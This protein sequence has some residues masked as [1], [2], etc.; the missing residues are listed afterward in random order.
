MHHHR[1][2]PASAPITYRG[3][4]LIIDPDAAARHLLS[5]FGLD[6]STGAAFTRVWHS[7]AC[8]LASRPDRIPV[9]ADLAGSFPPKDWQAVRRDFPIN[10][11]ADLNAAD[12]K[13]DLTTICFDDAAE[14]FLDADRAVQVLRLYEPAAFTEVVWPNCPVTSLGLTKPVPGMARVLSTWVLRPGSYLLCWRFPHRRP[15]LVT[16]ARTEQEPS[17]EALASLPG[18]QARRLTAVC[19]RCGRGW[20]AG[21][22]TLRF[23]LSVCC[24]FGG[25]WN[26]PEATGRT[27]T[28]VDCPSHECEGGRARLSN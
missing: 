2:Q 28:E 4:R 5:A 7:R 20:V 16:A 15:V 9:T 24:P 13:A 19:D 8:L 25:G 23:E 21:E 11:V 26:Y 22:G 27:G 18:F 17:R 10:F 12:I 3:R 6:A 14:R 1:L